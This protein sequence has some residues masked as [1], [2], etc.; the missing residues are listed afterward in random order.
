[1]E[2]CKRIIE[3]MSLDDM[4]ELLFYL[5]KEI[6]SLLDSEAQKDLILE[7]IGQSDD[8]KVTSMVHL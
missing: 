2:K 4:K 5:I 1:M 6:F 8:E 7:M 3:Q